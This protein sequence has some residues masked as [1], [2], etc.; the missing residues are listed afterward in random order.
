M[1]SDILESVTRRTVIAM[2]AEDRSLATVER[3]VDRTELYAADEVF[4]AGTG[5]EI[6]PIVTVDRQPVG[7]GE[8]GEV[9]R[10]LRERYRALVRGETADHPEW[11]TPVYTAG[12]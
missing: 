7:T 12:A 10:F 6:L 2:L 9:A 11:R 8:V 1:T 5:H 4:F 3:D